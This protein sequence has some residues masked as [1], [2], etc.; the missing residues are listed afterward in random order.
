MIANPSGAAS[1]VCNAPTYR[2]FSHPNGWWGRDS[3]CIL[4][5]AYVVL[6][7]YYDSSALTITYRSLPTSVSVQSKIMQQLLMPSAVPPRLRPCSV[8]LVAAFLLPS[9]ATIPSPPSR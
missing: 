9:M 5:S 7:N 1:C 2:S 6:E 8:M 4:S 3:S